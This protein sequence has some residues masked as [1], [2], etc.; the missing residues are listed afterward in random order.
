MNTRGATPFFLAARRADL[1]YMKLLVELGADP[2]IPNVDGAT[3]L[4]A[5]AGL[6]THAPGAV[7][8][9]DDLLGAGEGLELVEVAPE[10]DDGRVRPPTGST[11]VAVI[12]SG[13]RLPPDQVD[14]A[15]LRPDDR[16]VV[17]RESPDTIGA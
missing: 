17:L 15:E 4:M 10:A 7:R 5:A 16:L 1:P 2:L 12:R 8:V 6:G 14:P 3:S 13:A 11:L 9:L